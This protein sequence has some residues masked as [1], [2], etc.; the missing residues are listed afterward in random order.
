MGRVELTG[1]TV[2]S[3]SEFSFK[4]ERP[5][6]EANNVRSFVQMR[7]NG[8]VDPTSTGRDLW[9]MR[10]GS[11]SELACDWSQSERLNYF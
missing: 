7:E 2:Q 8:S 10:E 4:K 5:E 1:G 9:E 11:A 6:A 3:I